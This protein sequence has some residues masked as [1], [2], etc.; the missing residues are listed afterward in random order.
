MSFLIAYFTKEM[1][2]IKMKLNIDFSCSDKKVRDI[3]NGKEFDD[4]IIY[5]TDIPRFIDN[6]QKIY[7]N[8]VIK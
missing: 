7:D 3:L 4:E 1:E 8:C 5:W 2:V 6:L